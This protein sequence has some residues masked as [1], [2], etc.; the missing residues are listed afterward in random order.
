M[1]RKDSARSNPRR[2]TP[3]RT[4]GHASGLPV[5]QLPDGTLLARFGHGDEEVAVAF[6]RHFQRRAH[7]AALSVLVDPGL[8][9]DA[10]RQAFEQ[11]WRHGGG[12][13]SHCGSVSDWLMT[14]ACN[15][16]IDMA[17]ACRLVPVDIN[18]LLVQVAGSRDG[19]EAAALGGLDT[20]ELRAALRRLPEQRTRV[21]VMA[22]IA[23]MTA[24]QVAEIEGIPVGPAK[25]RDPDSHAAPTSRALSVRHLLGRPRPVANPVTA[26]LPSRRQG[27]GT[28][29]S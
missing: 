25:T 8:A 19:P 27:G 12:Y 6:V 3:V 22:G 11:A 14:I 15:V 24:V 5:E 4:W 16:S 21:V 29:A 28:D 7:S 9:E 26:L 17:R 1:Q 23:G 20:D 2:R 13:D 18:E 10:V